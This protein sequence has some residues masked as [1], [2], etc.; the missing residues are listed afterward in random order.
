MHLCQKLG[1]EGVRVPE[2]QLRWRVVGNGIGTYLGEWLKGIKRQGSSVPANKKQVFLAQHCVEADAALIV[3]I[4]RGRRHD[5]LASRIGQLVELLEIQCRRVE[6][7]LRNDVIRK[8]EMG[9]RVDDGCPAE[10]S[11]VRC[12]AVGT[13]ALKSVP[14]TVRCPSYPPKKKSLSFRIG[15]P[16]AAPN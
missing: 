2:Y 13:V 15:P 1:I 3:V 11:P 12:A 9:G 6:A 7:I 16:N 14:C 10:K 5:I 4:G 8:L